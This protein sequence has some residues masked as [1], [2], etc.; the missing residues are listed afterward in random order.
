MLQYY[1]KMQQ[2]A[3]LATVLAQALSVVFAV[4]LLVKKRTS[5]CNQK[6]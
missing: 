1:I 2:E 3:A 6:Q 4:V 5:I